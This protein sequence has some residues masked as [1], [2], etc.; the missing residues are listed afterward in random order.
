VIFVGYLFN[1]PASITFPAVATNS[2]N[3]NPGGARWRVSEFNNTSTRNVWT[4]SSSQTVT[5]TPAVATG[6]PYIW[7]GGLGPLTGSFRYTGSL[8]KRNHRKSNTSSR[9]GRCLNWTDIEHLSG[10]YR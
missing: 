8:D 10:L 7:A 3:T 9:R 1:N 2:T 5:I 6:T 4:N